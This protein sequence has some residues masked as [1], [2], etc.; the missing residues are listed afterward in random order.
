MRC[1]EKCCAA[2]VVDTDEHR[3]AGCGELF[4][5]E[6]I[7]PTTHDGLLCSADWGGIEH[8]DDVWGFDE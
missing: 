5:A 6:H 2:P 8:R 7:Y 1:A 4:C 3:C